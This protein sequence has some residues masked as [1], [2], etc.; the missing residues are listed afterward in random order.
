MTYLSVL[1][2]MLA[3]LDV[4]IYCL[5]QLIVSSAAASLRSVPAALPRMHSASI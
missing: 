2:I 4:Q 1:Y 5:L 3:L